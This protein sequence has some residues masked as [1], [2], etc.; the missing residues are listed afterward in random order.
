MAIS[1]KRHQRR[2]EDVV[3]AVLVILNVMV[4]RAGHVVRC[5]SNPFQSSTFS[6]SPRQTITTTT[7]K[8]QASRCQSKVTVSVDMVNDYCGQFEMG[9]VAVTDV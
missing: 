2:G 3:R 9:L 5:H 4:A 1:M 6:F 8:I 7:L